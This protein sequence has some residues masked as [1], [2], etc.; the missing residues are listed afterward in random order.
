MQYVR[1]LVYKLGFPNYNSKQEILVTKDGI[2][3][4]L[5][6]ILYPM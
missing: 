5:L 2:Y 1:Y 3:F 6:D 4:I